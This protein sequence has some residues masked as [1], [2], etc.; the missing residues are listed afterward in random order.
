M[1]TE[2]RRQ[3]KLEYTRYNNEIHHVDDFKGF[4]KPYPFMLCPGCAAPVTPVLGEERAHHA[5]HTVSAE[6]YGE[7]AEH[8]NAKAKLFVGLI[9]SARLDIKRF[10][11]CSGCSN[12]ERTLFCEN[13]NHVVLEHQIGSYRADLALIFDDRPIVAIEVMHT[14]EVPQEKVQYFRANGIEWL[15]VKA[16]RAHSWNSLSPM[17]WIRNSDTFWRCP[18]CESRTD[19]KE[20]QQI[21]FIHY[22]PTEFKVN[23]DWAIQW[24]RTHSLW[25]CAYCRAVSKNK[26]FDSIIHDIKTTDRVGNLILHSSECKYWKYLGQI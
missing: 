4:S 6:C 14:H 12:S 8:L 15:E 10:C 24:S 19:Q 13:W 22:P 21:K 25:H 7:S 3:V 18:D 16:E 20:E 11:H 5:R 17:P 1:P 2:Q 9:R 23:P 26:D